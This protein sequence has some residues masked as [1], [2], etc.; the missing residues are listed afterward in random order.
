M[1]MDGMEE[2]QQQV[3]DM[4][5]VGKKEEPTQEEDSK[6]EDVSDEKE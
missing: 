6:V 1:P 5:L 2:I 3:K 4:S